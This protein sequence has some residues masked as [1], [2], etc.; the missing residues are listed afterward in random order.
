MPSSPWTCFTPNI[1]SD[2]R[3]EA[4]VNDVLVGVLKT[5]WL[6]WKRMLPDVITAPRPIAPYQTVIKDI[7]Y[8]FGDASNQGIC[9]IVHAL[10]RTLLSSN[11]SPEIP[12]VTA[13]S[14]LAKLV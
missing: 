11:K 12:V 3:R 10:I 13:K 5:P 14:H 1:V 8:G 4:S 9:A 6:S 7:E 2:M